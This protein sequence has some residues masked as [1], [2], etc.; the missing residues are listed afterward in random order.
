MAAILAR[1]LEDMDN[2]PG[3]RVAK[4]VSTPLQP[5]SEPLEDP[6][7]P[8]AAPTGAQGE[9]ADLLAPRREKRAAGAIE[10]TT[11]ALEDERDATEESVEEDHDV[12]LTESKPEKGGQDIGKEL[13]V[14]R[15]RRDA[16]P[17]SAGGAVRLRRDLMEDVR[18]ATERFMQRGRE[19][20]MKAKEAFEQA[21]KKAQ[22]AAKGRS[23]GGA[24]PAAPSAP[25]EKK[26]EKPSDNKPEKPSEIPDEPEEDLSDDAEETKPTSRRRR[27]LPDSDAT[28]IFGKFKTEVRLTESIA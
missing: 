10:T 5:E 22:E 25:P 6:D 13:G 8:A 1:V 14:R 18:N 9:A 16:S 7:E 27:S 15:R 11:A 12:A 28:G 26:P 21:M 19:M 20:F 4:M 24:G 3:R 23:G 2:I 17:A